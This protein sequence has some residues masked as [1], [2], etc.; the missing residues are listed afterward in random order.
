MDLVSRAKGILLKPNE[1]WAKIKGEELTPAQLF[2]NYAIIL[3]AVPAVAQF[4]GRILMGGA[5]VPFTGRSIMGR[6][7]F[8]SVFYYIALLA[9]AY[10]L[11]FIINALAPSF[12][13][14]QNLANAMKLAVFSM[15]PVWLAGILYILP[16]LGLLV[17]LAMF[18]SYFLL[19]LG[20]DASLMETPKDKVVGYF[21]ISAVAAV[22]IYIVAMTLV[23]GVF[24][25]GTLFRFF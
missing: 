20:F 25:G 24:W 14:K 4:L 10:L 5:R 22:V 16:F 6:S 7:F 2:T 21:V 19:Y 8:Y 3:A 18:Y 13:S 11:G 15:T 1:E 12:S 23:W 17:Y 9:L